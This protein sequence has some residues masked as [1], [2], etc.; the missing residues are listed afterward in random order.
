M[1]QRILLKHPFSVRAIRIYP[2]PPYPL[3]KTGSFRFPGLIPYLF[4]QLMASRIY[5]C[6]TKNISS[7]YTA[8]S[9]THPF[10]FLRSLYTELRHYIFRYYF[11]GLFHFI[12]ALIDD[13]L[14]Y[15]YICVCKRKRRTFNS[16]RI[17]NVT[18]RSRSR[19]C[20]IN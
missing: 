5:S 9:Y 18:T 19:G 20:A 16:F 13:A 4:S 3:C 1:L 11:F 12:F 7:F 2:L 6:T 17:Q 14:V 15:I 8:T 10:D